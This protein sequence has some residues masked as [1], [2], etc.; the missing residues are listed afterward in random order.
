MTL[1]TSAKDEAYD[2]AQ[3]RRETRDRRSFD[4]KLSTAA[5]LAR[6]DE[7]IAKSGRRVVAKLLERRGDALLAALSPSDAGSARDEVVASAALLGSQ[8]ATALTRESDGLDR[9]R[10]LAFLRGMDPL[11]RNADSPPGPTSDPARD[12]P[13][14]PAS[15]GGYARYE[16]TLKGELLLGT[17][18][19][20]DIPS[21]RAPS[22]GVDVH[23]RSEAR[24]LAPRRR[25]PS[26]LQFL[27]SASGTLG[28]GSR[29]SDD[30][31]GPDQSGFGFRL[32]VDYTALLGARIR[33]VGLFAGARAGNLRVHR[34]D[35][36]GLRVPG[37]VLRSR[38]KR[39][40][41][42]T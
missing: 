12:T 21:G 19:S 17:L 23:G 40:S 3:G 42:R 38:R 5:V 18:A 27:D 35:Q 25:R 9:D 33:Q 20:A 28:L 41:S 16:S 39:D 37:A 8:R 6:F 11:P 13:P 24:R 10:M 29:T 15:R 2:R 14:S 22:R 34:R 31:V 4:A 7:D 32:D 1:A 26:G 36:H 30:V